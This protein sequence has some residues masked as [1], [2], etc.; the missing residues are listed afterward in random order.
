ML[1]QQ[2]IE[3]AELEEQLVVK[4]QKLKEENYRALMSTTLD[5]V[6]EE[7]VEHQR[8]LQKIKVKLKEYGRTTLPQVGP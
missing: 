7:H 5:I 8:L 2:Q 4:D 3:L 6:G 1:L